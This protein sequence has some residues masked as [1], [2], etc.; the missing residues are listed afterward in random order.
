M[1]IN[2]SFTLRNNLLWITAVTFFLM[3]VGDLGL[4]VVDPSIDSIKD[5]YW[6]T[7]IPYAMFITIWIS[8]LIAIYAFKKN[9][10]I[11]ESFYPNQKGN[12]IRYLNIGL[13]AGFLLNGICAV[14]A[15]LCH[16]IQLS[17]KTFELIPFI[18]LLLVVFI[19]SSA[20]ELLCRGFLY[21][22]I[23]ESKGSYWLAILLNAVFFGVAHLGNDGISVLGF[24]DLVITGIFFSM[25]VFYFDSLWMAFGIHT[26]WNFTQSILLGLP[27]S[28][29]S[30]PYS[31]F[32]LNPNS[33]N[34]FS[35]SV[36]FGLEGTILSSILMT[37]CCIG[38]YVW[39]NKE[40]N[41]WSKK[42]NPVIE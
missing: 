34:G 22:R 1:K 28:G 32:T 41:I 39:K 42:L 33:T 20:E 23:L 19:Q 8:L 31:V 18:G 4:L 36:T 7:F 14:T 38:L 30:F 37:I 2:K 40:R 11:K 35:Y 16:N 24:Y 17:F 3:V 25:V 6:T 5:P 21:Q 9:N 13:I 26:T 29:T 10:Y 15:L 27:N 12:T